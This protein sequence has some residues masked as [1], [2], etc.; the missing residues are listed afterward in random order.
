MKNLRNFD[1]SVVGLWGPGDRLALLNERLSAEGEAA[2]STP[3]QTNTE[4]LVFISEEEV[5]LL[6]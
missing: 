6:Q 1:L 5:L 2:G 4:G 3:G